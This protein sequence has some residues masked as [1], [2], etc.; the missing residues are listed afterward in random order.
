MIHEGMIDRAAQRATKDPTNETMDTMEEMRSSQ[1]TITPVQWAG[2]AH[3]SE[4]DP[5]LLRRMN[6]D[7]KAEGIRGSED[8]VGARLIFQEAIAQ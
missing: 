6:E 7:K 4:E 5:D 8:G 3:V 1:V 2:K